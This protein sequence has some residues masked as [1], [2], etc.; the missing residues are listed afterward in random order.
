MT[1]WEHHSDLQR[2]RLI[3]V[4]RLIH[5]GRNDALDRQDARVGSIP[6]TVG[7]EAFA[8]GMHQISEAAP[9]LD[10]LEVI[11]PGMQFVFRIGEVPV[12][13]YKGAPD[14][15]NKRTLRQTYSELNQLS[16]FGLDEITSSERIYRFAIETDFDGAVAAI[17]FVVLDGETPVLTWNVPLDEPVVR[18]APLDVPDA[19]GVDLPK[20]SVIAPEL[21]QKK[22][23]ETGDR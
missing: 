4:G 5:Q 19:K 22:K 20:P 15:P 3:E 1:P 17:S 14:E 12:R 9:D 7:C 23:G 2:E 18:I 11:Q 16:L 13:F 21:D 6:W 8:F 10:W